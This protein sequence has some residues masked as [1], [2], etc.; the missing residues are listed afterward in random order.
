M[1]RS[2]TAVG[3][4]QPG[5][6]DELPTVAVGGKR[7]FQD[8]RRAAVV[9]LAVRRRAAAEVVDPD[10]AGTDGELP[11]AQ[12]GIGRAARSLRSEALVDLVVRVDHDL[13]PGGVEIVPQRLQDRKSTRLNSSHGYISY[14][15]FCLKKK[16]GT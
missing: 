11:D 8:T 10:A 3:E 7:E 4:A 5:N 2:A 15:V 1:A 14:A 9:H 6:R 12:L 16:N 13:R